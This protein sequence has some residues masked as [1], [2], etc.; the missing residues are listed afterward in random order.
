MSGL[1]QAIVPTV[2]SSAIVPGE[3]GP[4]WL[5]PGEGETEGLTLLEM[6]EE[7]LGLLE[8]ETEALGLWLGLTL[9]D[10]LSGVPD[11]INVLESFWLLYSVSIHPA[12]WEI[13]EIRASSII[14]LK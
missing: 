13:F 1:L 3:N 14:P 7:I 9:G 12:V 8:G 6:L 10:G 11:I 4:C 2:S 5:Y